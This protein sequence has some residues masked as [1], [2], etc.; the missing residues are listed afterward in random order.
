MHRKIDAHVDTLPS[1]LVLGNQLPTEFRRYKGI[2]LDLFCDYALSHHWQAVDQRPL[3]HY[4]DA[5][6]AQLTPHHR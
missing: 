3:D 6:I 1:L 2:L 4:I 5:T